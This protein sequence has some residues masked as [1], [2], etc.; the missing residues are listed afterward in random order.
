MHSIP[1]KVEVFDLRED[2]WEENDL[3]LSG[4]PAPTRNQLLG[5][6]ARGA[7]GAVGNGALAPLPELCR[8][9]TTAAS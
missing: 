7:C 1:F 2:P 4:V 6:W 5:I 3:G 9:G 8:E